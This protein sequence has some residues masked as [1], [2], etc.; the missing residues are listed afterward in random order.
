VIATCGSR[1][2]ARSSA[3]HTTTWGEGPQWWV[4]AST[5]DR[6]HRVPE[7]ERLDRPGGRGQG[8]S[9]QVEQSEPDHVVTVPDGEEKA[10]RREGPA[11]RVQ[12]LH[13]RREAPRR[14]GHRGRKPLEDACGSAGVGHRAGGVARGQGLPGG[15]A[16]RPAE[17]LAPG[18][19]GD[20]GQLGQQVVVVLRG[21]VEH[22][23]L[24]IRVSEDRGEGGQATTRFGHAKRLLPA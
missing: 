22:R 4:V 8:G 3:S 17:L 10:E 9:L 11:A 20:A 18:P 7:V 6:A 1:P 23:G 12:H 14:L 5:E 24:D 13:R 15:E 16:H 21:A 19:V 2:N